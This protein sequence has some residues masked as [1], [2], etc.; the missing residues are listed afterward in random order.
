MSHPSR[1]VH[2]K[3]EEHVETRTH[4]LVDHPVL[5]LAIDALTEPPTSPPLLE[6]SQSLMA[7]AAL[8]IYRGSLT[9]QQAYKPRVALLAQRTQQTRRAC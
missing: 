3:Q 8:F 4:I 5:H 2:H 9:N 6:F 7:T 1:N